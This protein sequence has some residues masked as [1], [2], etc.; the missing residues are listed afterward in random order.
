MLHAFVSGD[1]KGA[2][3]CVN[4]YKVA[5]CRHDGDFCSFLRGDEGYKKKKSGR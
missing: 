1:D 5:Y 3:E 2:S 4:G